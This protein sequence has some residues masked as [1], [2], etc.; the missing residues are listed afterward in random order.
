MRD[1]LIREIL[2][3]RQR[4]YSLAP[5]T[6]LQELD[7]Q[8]DFRCF[9]KRED[10]SPINAYKWRGAY[11]R[12]QQLSADDLAKGVITASA[13]NHAQGVALSAKKLGT[14][15]KIYMPLSTPKMKQ[16]AVKRLGGDQVEVVLIG[17]SYDEAS[18]E[19]KRI[20]AAEGIAYIHAYDDLQVMARGLLLTKLLCQE[21]V[22]SMWCFSRLAEGDWPVPL[23]PGLNR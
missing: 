14:K 19:A 13:G 23:L 4:V 7:L 5:A 20:S 9:I 2:L 17:D 10:L 12:M 15:A 18:A 11:N 22:L 3:A 21:K 6:P 8:L 16:N 1:Q